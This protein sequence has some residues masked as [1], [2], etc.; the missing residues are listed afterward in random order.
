M[1]DLD[2]SV[3]IAERDWDFFFQESEECN[4]QQAALAGLDESGLSDFDESEFCL[5]NQD[6]TLSPVV[7]AHNSIEGSHIKPYPNSEG[8]F[9]PEN[10][11]S[12]GE[13]EKC[14][15][16][17]V[18]IF[19]PQRDSQTNAEAQPDANQPAGAE[20]LNDCT[21]NPAKE[22][23]RW[24]VTDAADVSDAA[25]SG[26]F[27]HPYDSK[28]DSKR[29]SGDSSLFSDFEEEF[30]QTPNGS[31]NPSPEPEDTKSSALRSP[32]PGKVWWECKPDPSYCESDNDAEDIMEL[33]A[34]GTAPQLS[35]IR[36]PSNHMETAIP[37]F[38]C[39]RSVKRKL[40]FIEEYDYFFPEDSPVESEDEDECTQVHVV[41]CYSSQIC[42]PLDIS[43]GPDM[44]EHFFT[45]KDWR[46]NLFW[47]HPF[48]LR[49]V[50]LTGVLCGL[51]YME[52]QLSSPLSMQQRDMD[53]KTAMSFPR[54]N[55]A[56]ST[57]VFP[58]PLGYEKT[59]MSDVLAFK[60][61][62]QRKKPIFFLVIRVLMFQA[63]TP[64]HVPPQSAQKQCLSRLGE[65]VRLK[66]AAEGD[67]PRQLGLNW[68]RIT[69]SIQMQTQSRA[70]TQA[71]QDQILSCDS[72][73]CMPAAAHPACWPELASCFWAGVFLYLLPSGGVCSL[74]VEGSS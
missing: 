43:A 17:F 66:S 8:L 18:D 33:S 30:L 40:R 12:R 58:S 13:D 69:Q 57:Q 62:C 7:S 4:L 34:E 41:S 61:V 45:D 64:G 32:Q 52:N 1:D 26:Y 44:Y 70:V 50:Q 74:K 15:E 9:G 51:L 59:F 37:I 2:H 28:P 24:F 27:P 47:R 68:G 56:A 39:S 22:K 38:S 67:M 25:D 5:S 63:A 21:G 65:K 60:P 42:E 6:E 11:L 31:A 29:S 46:G 14:L 48:S 54:N 53:L 3:H 72:G 71:R 49:R 23:E 35:D 10:S 73:V 36:R 19:E 20:P 16:T 55:S